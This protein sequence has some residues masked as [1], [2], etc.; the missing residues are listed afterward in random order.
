VEE[1]II[2]NGCVYSTLVLRRSR[3][4]MVI[5]IRGT[6]IIII[7]IILTTKSVL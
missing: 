7:Y 2:S 1:V 3:G 6:I 5:I 4:T